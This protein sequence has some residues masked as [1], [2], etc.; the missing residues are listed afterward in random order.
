M[1]RLAFRAEM[2]TGVAQVITE[3][4][5]TDKIPG[6]QAAVADINALR[7]NPQ[8]VFARHR[9]R[10]S[11]MVWP[12]CTEPG[13]DNGRPSLLD[14]EL[15]PASPICFAICAGRRSSPAGPKKFGIIRNSAPGWKSSFLEPG[16]PPGTRTPSSTSSGTW[17]RCA[18]AGRVGLFEN[19]NATPPAFVR[20]LVYSKTD[21]T[22]AARRV[23]DYVGIA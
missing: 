15:S 13:T 18:H 14:R 11:G 1:T 5:G 19:V 8:G 12:A 6:V 2:F 10:V 3:I 22:A 16:S 17:S 4:L 9:S 21:R 7:T 23:R 20:N